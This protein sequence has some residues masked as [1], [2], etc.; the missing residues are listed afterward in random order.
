MGGD[1]SYHTSDSKHDSTPWQAKKDRARLQGNTWWRALFFVLQLWYN[2]RKAAMIPGDCH[3]LLRLL[4]KRTANDAIYHE[5]LRIYGIIA[6][7][8][9]KSGA[10]P[11]LIAR[12]LSCL[13]VTER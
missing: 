7:E 1:F 8:R 3:D 13:G 4:R 2:S 9:Q 5:M 11:C 10:A 6:V 12:A